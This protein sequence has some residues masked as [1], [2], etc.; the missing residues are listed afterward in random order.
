MLS[1]SDSG[2]CR[3]RASVGTYGQF[4]D[5]AASGGAVASKVAAHITVSADAVIIV[6]T[7][8]KMTGPTPPRLMRDFRC[9]C[10]S[11]FTRAATL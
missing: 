4:A 5:Q 7:Q 11:G 6:L 2:P 8:V 9:T 10:E 1:L 3:L